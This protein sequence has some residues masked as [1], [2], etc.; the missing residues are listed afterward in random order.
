M[1]AYRGGVLK[2]SNSTGVLDVFDIRRFFGARESPGRVV[3]GLARPCLR[4]RLWGDAVASSP[5]RRI[6]AALGKVMFPFGVFGDGV[7][8]RFSHTGFGSRHQGVPMQAALTDDLGGQRRAAP[9]VAVVILNHNRWLL[10]V[11]CLEAVQ[12]ID[13]GNWI[14]IVLDNGSNDDSVRYF[15][16]WSVGN[17]EVRSPYVK[18]NPGSKPVPMRLIDAF[19]SKPLRVG[20]QFH[21]E[22]RGWSLV[23]LAKNVGFAA[24]A[25]I[26][27]ALATQQSADFV[28][29][30]NNDAVPARSALSELVQC[31]L[32]DP[33]IGMAG[34]KLLYYDRPTHLQAAGGGRLLVWAGITRHYGAGEE[35]R[36]QW[37]RSFEPD[38][39][40]G[41]SLLL[42]MASLEQVGLFDETFFF[43]GE[44]VDWQLRARRLGWRALYCPRS[45]VYHRE[46]A[47]IGRNSVR[48]DYFSAVVGLQL[49]RRYA[50]WWLPSAV[51]FHLIRAGRRV[52]RGQ[53]R[54]ARAI[55]AGI[56]DALQGP[57]KY[58]GGSPI[59]QLPAPGRSG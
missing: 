47:T 28:W 13:Y 34:S 10:T 57:G 32:A 38:Y 22:A 50:A 17:L 29:L 58:S 18:W 30:V 56:L 15:L 11:E 59:E 25:N 37:N 43:Y 35:D 5:A 7:S 49:C 6:G 31:A 45:I 40:T 27:I 33:R 4:L 48:A 46:A 8:R 52:V 19:D 41:A 39:V 53:F 3:C 42:R 12:Q 55:L 21:A 14:G 2:V 51:A 24:G 44:E 20:D 1:A 54:R 26:G 9:R 36:G 23:R 16:D